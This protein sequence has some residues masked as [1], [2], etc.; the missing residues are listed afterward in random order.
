MSGG[1]TIQTS[2]PWVTSGQWGGGGKNKSYPPTFSINIIRIRWMSR[3]IMKGGKTQKMSQPSQCWWGDRD[4]LCFPFNIESLAFMV[5]YKRLFEAPSFP[6]NRLSVNY[7]IPL[8]RIKTRQRQVESLNFFPPQSILRQETYPP[9]S[10]DVGELP[11]RIQSWEIPEA[12]VTGVAYCC[13]L[14]S[15]WNQD[16]E[17]SCL[18]LAIC[19]QMFLLWSCPC[20]SPGF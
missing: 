7:F 3:A 10:S 12:F 8:E 4:S 20:L 6:A 15:W 11:H 16:T 14:P 9:L 17:W 13:D 18:H 1:E 19:S 2:N 5:T